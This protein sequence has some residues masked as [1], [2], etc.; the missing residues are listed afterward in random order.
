MPFNIGGLIVNSS[1]SLPG[2]GTSCST[3]ARSGLE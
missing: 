2:D 1:Y 3:T